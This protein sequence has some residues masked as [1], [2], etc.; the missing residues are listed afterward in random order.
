MAYY[1]YYKLQKYINGQ[2]T[3]EYS[4]GARV[5]DIEY[6]SYN[7]CMESSETQTRWTITSQTVCVGND[8]YYVYKEQVSYD[9]GETWSDTGNTRPGDNPF[10]TNSR[11]CGY[12]EQWKFLDPATDTD[13]IC[14]DVTKDKYSRKQKQIS[15]DYGQT[16]TDTN[17]YEKWYVIEEKSVDCGALYQWVDDPNGGYS[18]SGY[19]KMLNQLEQVSIDDGTTWQN[20]GN[21][22]PGST[23]IET[24]SADCGYTTEKMLEDYTDLSIYSITSVD[25]NDCFNRG[26]N[27]YP[28]EEGQYLKFKNNKLGLFDICSGTMTD[29]ELNVTET[30]WLTSGEGILYYDEND[31]YK[32][33]KDG[34]LKVRRKSDAKI[35]S[36]TDDTNDYLCMTDSDKAF[37]IGKYDIKFYTLNWTNEAKT[38]TNTIDLSEHFPSGVYKYIRRA[39][40]Q[41]SNRVIGGYLRMEYDNT[42]Y[43]WLFTIDIDTKEVVK[44]KKYLSET[45][46]STS[47]AGLNQFNIIHTGWHIEYHLTEGKHVIVNTDSKTYNNWNMFNLY[48]YNLSSQVCPNYININQYHALL[49][50]VETIEQWV[51]VSGEYACDG[52]DKYNLEK[53]QISINGGLTWE[54]TGLTRKG[55]T[56]I[57]ADDPDCVAIGM[58]IGTSSGKTPTNN[59]GFIITDYDND[60]TNYNFKIKGNGTNL[61]YSRSSQ[62]YK[63]GLKHADYVDLTNVTS[64]NSFFYQQRNLETVDLSRW[65][66]R[67]IQTFNS[68][69]YDTRSLTTLDLSNWSLDSVTSLSGFI[70]DSYKTSVTLPTSCTSNYFSKI[71]NA[72]RGGWFKNSNL[73]TITNWNLSNITEAESVFYGSVLLSGDISLMTKNLNFQ[74]LSYAS[75]MFNGCTGIT[76]ID[77]STWVFKYSSTIT[78]QI[79]D[80]VRGCVLLSDFIMDG[81]D[82]SVFSGANGAYDNMF[83]GCTSLTTISMKGA[84]L[85]QMGYNNHMFDGC[86]SLTTI[87]ATGC[88]LT[89]ISTLNTA[90]SYAGLTG[91]VTIIQ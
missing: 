9:G 10:Q 23:V 5:N 71:S 54:D 6:S 68:M 81:V 41:P 70:N 47:Q 85:S 79:D 89:T 91:N 2:P 17:I 39:F 25:T 37:T 11:D 24:E 64:L 77:I 57:Q 19:N 18:C 40:Y 67:N 49:P 65:D 28:L 62:T 50:C 16:W 88:D 13:Y 34:N 32:C 53:Q 58:W 31:L 20:T 26:V 35:I 14:D 59:T 66:V 84:K 63:G 1:R 69:F 33:Y 55:S 12:M 51:T 7:E 43:Y 78:S 27:A 44:L 21:T 38:L 86:S 74:N 36:I 76:K 22:R 56:L 15:R 45:A 60:G 75:W 3:G 48:T 82:L 52:D 87:D 4:Q 30:D 72:F 73:Q 61:S 29:D 90:L 83:R 8:K 80:F 42:G 46:I